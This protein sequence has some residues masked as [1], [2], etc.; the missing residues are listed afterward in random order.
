MKI[1]FKNQTEKMV[2][3]GVCTA[4]IIVL[5]QIS[6]P[7][8]SG[9]P[10]TL[11]TF[12]IAICGFLLGPKLATISTVLYIALGSIGLPVFASFSGGF[13][14][15]IGYTGGFI[16]GF[17]FMALLCGFACKFNNKFISISFGILGL[18]ACDIC[19]AFQYGLIAQMN[20]F[21]SFALVAAPYL[22]K[23][24]ICVILAYTFV[25]LVI[26]ALQKSKLV[27]A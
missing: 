13:S 15:V 25:K 14:S 22:V 27:S 21:S 16:W 19:G 18:L 5:S 1:N 9:V 23:D 24:I 26:V 6:I 7:M 17:I 8:P 4:L 3:T 20:F 2:I 10:I 11:Q 12:A